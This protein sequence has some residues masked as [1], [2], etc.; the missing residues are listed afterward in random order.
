M[1]VL[2]FENLQFKWSIISV[3]ILIADVSNEHRCN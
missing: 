1:T 3:V 2:Y